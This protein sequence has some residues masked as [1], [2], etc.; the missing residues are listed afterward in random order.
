MSIP[1]S[2][3]LSEALGAKQLVVVMTQTTLSA[4]SVVICCSIPACVGKDEGHAIEEN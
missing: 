3:A 1:L 2:R 4:P